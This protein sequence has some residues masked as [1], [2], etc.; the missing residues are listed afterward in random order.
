MKR[1]L[2]D[3]KCHFQLIDKFSV[4]KYEKG[5]NIIL[6][7]REDVSIY[8]ISVKKDNCYNFLK[9]QYVKIIVIYFLKKI[10]L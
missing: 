7:I 3:W 4:I 6:E 9:V 8:H 1:L 2:S 10:L 5:I